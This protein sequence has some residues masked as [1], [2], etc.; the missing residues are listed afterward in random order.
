[1]SAKLIS[2]LGFA[3][4]A[5]TSGVLFAADDSDALNVNI[6]ADFSK[7]KEVY[8]DQVGIFYEDLGRAAD[9]GLYAELVENRDFE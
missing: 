2:A 7:T 3:A 6:S 1:M 8:K 4:F 5:V 9:G